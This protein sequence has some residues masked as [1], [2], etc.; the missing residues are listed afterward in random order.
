MFPT[1]LAHG[2]F[3]SLPLAS[4]CKAS[5]VS[6]RWRHFIINSQSLWKNLDFTLNRPS[7][8]ITDQ[9]VST[10]VNRGK[11]RIQTF[12]CRNAERLSERTLK[13]LRAVPCHNLKTFELA[14]NSSI[15]ETAIVIFIRTIG[16]QLKTI[17]LSN[18][19]TSD[20]AVKT[21]LM[22]CPQLE[23]L[24]L[25]LCKITTQAFDLGDKQCEA[26]KVRELDLNG[27]RSIDKAVVSFIIIL[28]PN[29]THLNIHGISGI[30]THTLVNL[31]HLPNLECISMFGNMYEDGLVIEDAFLTF[32]KSCPLLRQ[33]AL[34]ECPDLTDNCVRHLVVSCVN[35]EELTLN[36]SY[37]LTD[38]ATQYIGNYCNR[39]KILRIGKSPGITDS[40][41]SLMLDLGC[42]SLLEIIEL[43][44]NNI[45]DNSLRKLADCCDKLKMINVNFCPNITGS[46]VAYLVKKC[47]K[48]MQHLSMVDCP[49][50]AL[51]AADLARRVLGQ[52]GGTVNY[53]FRALR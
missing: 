41:I 26:L 13:A 28:F 15:N 8:T 50:V 42:G 39:L 43:K 3:E 32:A 24:N 30:T 27:C 11:L 19:Q 38:E 1:E 52:H 14:S 17:N 40:G 53:L 20:R 48:L 47:G 49:N 51:D 18:T 46:G 33:F 6:K 5:I 2:I 25:S 23:T 45:T 10:Y 12:I 37:N 31:A 9:V 29:I 21:M 7:G 16:S 4:L 44:Q 34:E 35:L 36:G 22:H